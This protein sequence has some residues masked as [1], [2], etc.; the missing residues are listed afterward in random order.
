MSDTLPEAIDLAELSERQTA[1]NE[2]NFEQSA[3]EKYAST[4]LG[5]CLLSHFS[6]TGLVIYGVIDGTL[7]AGVITLVTGMY[8]YFRWQSRKDGVG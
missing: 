6:A 5:M 3:Y 8:Q 1:I 7:W 4:K 2:N